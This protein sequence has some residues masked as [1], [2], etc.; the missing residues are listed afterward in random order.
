VDQT[1]RHQSARSGIHVGS[2]F[3][4]A[5][6]SICRS[7]MRTNR[8]TARCAVRLF[9]CSLL[10]GFGGPLARVPPCIKPPMRLS[11]GRSSKRKCQPRSKPG[12]CGA[13]VTGSWRCSP[14]LLWERPPGADD[15]LVARRNAGA[16]LTTTAAGEQWKADSATR[17]S[18]SRHSLSPH[19]RLSP[20]WSTSMKPAVGIQVH[21]LER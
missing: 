16:K 10:L 20:R 12:A 18:P 17:R 9:G 19:H 5:A 3:T 15:S 13:R 8:G 6:L 2:G 11:V 1:K 21:H 4:S 7:A 14:A